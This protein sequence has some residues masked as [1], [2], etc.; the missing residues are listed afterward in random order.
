MYIP[1]ARHNGQQ[2]LCGGGDAPRQLER[3]PGEPRTG[4]PQNL[5]DGLPVPQARRPGAA[6]DHDTAGG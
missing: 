1:P 4:A 5:R 2:L 6:G 3:V